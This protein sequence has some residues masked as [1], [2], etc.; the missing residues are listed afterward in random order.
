MDGS[1]TLTLT[2][3]LLALEPDEKARAVL[4]AAFDTFLQFGVRRA[5][6]QD[7]ADRAGMS[8]AALY[9]HFKN[10]DDIFR[11]MMSNYF[12]AAADVAE[13]VLASDPDPVTALQRAFDAQAGEMTDRMM[14]SPHVG[15]MLEAKTGAVQG[16]VRE[17]EM[18]LTAVYADWLARGVAEGRLSDEAVGPDPSQTAAMILSSLFS[19]KKAGVDAAGY[20]AARAHLAVMFGRALR[21]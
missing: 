17:G 12:L 1:S 19:L 18:R 4:W 6:M 21:V 15:E 9:L 13:A 7:I 2:D 20:A 16:I 8:R 14:D 5:S 10:K 11:A 3:R